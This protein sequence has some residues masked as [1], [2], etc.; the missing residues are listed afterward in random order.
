MVNINIVEDGFWKKHAI[1]NI[2]LWV[3]G[4]I[5]SHTIEE[6]VNICKYIKTDDLLAFV[7]SIDGH[8]ALVIQRVDLTFMAVDK[9]RSIP[10]FWIENEDSIIIDSI[11]TNLVEQLQSKELD[12]EAELTFSMS[13][14]TTGDNTLYRELHSLLAGE[15]LLIDGKSK[16]I[17][18]QKYHVYKP[19]KV[20]N[21]SHENYLDKLTKVTLGVFKKTLKS[22]GDRQIVIPLSAGNDSRLVVSCLYH[23]GAKNV[24]C[25]TYG[26]KDNFESKISKIIANKLGYKWY[27]HELTHKEQRSFYKS[28]LFNKFFNFANSYTSIP[29]FQDINS[30]KYLKENGFVDEDA[31]FINGNSGDYI[32][33]GHIKKELVEFDKT[34]TCDEKKDIIY[35]EMFKKHFDLWKNLKIEDNHEKLKVIMDNQVKYYLQETVFFEN[36]HGMFEFLE[37]YNR[38]SKYV[39]S[40][41]RSYEFFNFDWRLPLWDNEYIDFWESV[42]AK[43]KFEQ[44]LYIDMLKKNNW[45]NVWNNDIP[46][47][48][49]EISPKW[50]IPVRFLFKIPFGLF[51]SYGKKQ[52]KQFDISFFDYWMDV[53]HQLDLFSYI[54]VI[55][56][57]SKGG[58]NLDSYASKRY[59]E[60]IKNGKETW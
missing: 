6:I 7:N 9:I 56:G 18:K 24:V 54:K 29:F 13:A 20:V 3:K 8:F 16:K 55:R 2:Y 40:G 52:W 44:K 12:K 58:K 48:K 22:I 17:K 38:Q 42:P 11:A 51:G 5:Y 27:F 43:Y 1:E 45:G 47:N 15:V 53:T 4:Y 50:I 31:V 34:L 23:L 57:F 35:N 32:S 33:G 36:I 25:F 10:L 14:Y 30:L 19:W 39:I 59:L 49:K 46:I 60:Y 28:E 21:D 37:F 26:S 41:Q